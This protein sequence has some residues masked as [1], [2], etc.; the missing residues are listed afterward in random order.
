MAAYGLD[1]PEEQAASSS[2][3]RRVKFLCSFGGRILPRP[4]DGALRYV[5]GHTRII[6]LRK[7]ASFQELK[8][9]MFDV[10]GGPA[11]LKYQLPDEDLDA[12]VTVSCPEDLEN[13]MEE[14]DKLAETSP[15]GS[16]K[17]RVFLFSPAEVD[18]P[19]LSFA[20]GVND[21]GHRYVDVV[22]GIADPGAAELK[23]KGSMASFSSAQTSDGAP[24]ELL[25]C[26]L[27][28]ASPAISSPTVA[29]AG[30]AA[31]Q[32]PF[33]LL[34][35]G[36]PSDPVTAPADPR[37]FPGELAPP[38]VLPSSRP[39]Q[40]LPLSS[41]VT[42]VPL[43]YLESLQDGYNRMD[44]IQNPGQLQYLNAPPLGMP[45]VPVSLVAVPQNSHVHSAGMTAPMSSSKVNG[46]K[47]V[48]RGAE[49]YSDG[50]FYGGRI[51]SAA[52]DPPYNPLQPFSQ[53]Q[54]SPSLQM[55]NAERQ[56]LRQLPQQAAAAAPP[57]YSDSLK[58][59]PGGS[60][61]TGSVPINRP[62]FHTLQSGAVPG[63]A[64]ESPLKNIIPPHQYVDFFGPQKLDNID[65]SKVF[66][67]LPSLSTAAPEAPYSHLG[68]HYQAWHDDILQQQQPPVGP[69]QFLRR[70]DPTIHDPARARIPASRKDTAQNSDMELP[71]QAPY[72]HQPQFPGLF[73]HQFA[74]PKPHVG[75]PSSV[76]RIIE[77]LWSNT[78][79]ASAINE[80]WRTVV[81]PDTS[82]QIETRP[83]SLQTVEGNMG[84][85]KPR[86]GERETFLGGPSVDPAQVGSSRG[87]H[88]P[89]T[90]PPIP[91]DRLLHGPSAATAKLPV[92]ST[93]R[94][95]NAQV[96]SEASLSGIPVPLSLTLPGDLSTVGARNLQRGDIQLPVDSQ[97]RPQEPWYIMQNAQSADPFIDSL[98]RGECSV[99]D[100]EE[101][102][103]QRPLDSLIR[104]TAPDPI[105][106]VEGCCPS[107]PFY[108][109]GRSELVMIV[110][111]VFS[112]I[113]RL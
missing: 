9:K 30:A 90:D 45:S 1:S 94:D 37:A 34:Y 95:E 88:G 5:G 13:M 42:Y 71:V 111:L 89:F 24:G 29:E 68:D 103:Y 109:D 113:C 82:A 58:Q 96:F 53:P 64:V 48:Q 86:V 100:M 7:D 81:K 110:F 22:N 74:A 108:P 104:G 70:Q 8:R 112:D 85:P 26:T 35:P 19:A 101:G 80:P 54:P 16:A 46:G 18:S 61:S 107:S 21:G 66:H 28:A 3:S 59:E 2:S 17:L 44:Y 91:H 97:S 49:A 39:E 14:Y 15:E 102:G 98:Y 41:G 69:P 31:L 99:A 52:G 32:D 76:D 60:G 63:A 40:P 43:A 36:L 75:E 77:K 87:G 50:S 56:G 10:F 23:R 106:A 67:P 6:A 33:R 4:S 57:L 73:E 51:A 55:Q 105:T 20:P 25:D 27:E 84:N 72:S 83:D 11:I 92:G 38:Q 93:W 79:E 62:E 12:L 78:S 47:P 65:Q